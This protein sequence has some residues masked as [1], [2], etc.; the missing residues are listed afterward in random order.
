MPAAPRLAPSPASDATVLCC[1]ALRS[2]L[3][4][5]RR[6]YLSG[7]SGSCGGDAA[8]ERKMF[9]SSSS[10]EIVCG[11]IM[12][13][14]LRGG[15]RGGD[16]LKGEKV[17]SSLSGILVLRGKRGG[18]LRGDGGSQMVGAVDFGVKRGRWWWRLYLGD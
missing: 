10:T 18:F 5:T 1:P 9:P 2:V 11:W 17:I 4:G 3:L 8:V 16:L 13:R 7:V 15:T 6:G 14:A 12:K